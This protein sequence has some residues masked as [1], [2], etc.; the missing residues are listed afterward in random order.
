MS[1]RS[2]GH[3]SSSLS[4]IYLLLRPSI[5]LG[6]SFEGRFESYEEYLGSDS[7]YSHMLSPT[8]LAQV[9]GRPEEC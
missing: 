1:I 8:R 5:A 6:S 7:G 2:L 4:P 9:T 3:V